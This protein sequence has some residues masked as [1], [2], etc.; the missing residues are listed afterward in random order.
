MGTASTPGKDQAQGGTYVISTI[1]FGKIYHAVGPRAANTTSLTISSNT[2]RDLYHNMLA[3]AN[4]DKA[5]QAIVLP[6][7]AT[8]IFA[9]AGKG[10]TEQEFIA[11]IY[12]GMQAGICAF[13]K[14]CPDHSFTII[15]N[16]WDKEY[17]AHIS[18]LQTN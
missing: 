15:L 11:T 9:S 18:A 13:L 14:D 7:I 2:V 5:I 4:Q 3:Q 1:Q 17:V 8:G 10:F 12:Q 16:S 6:A